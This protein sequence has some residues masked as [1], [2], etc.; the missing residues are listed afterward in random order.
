MNTPKK[1]QSITERMLERRRIQGVDGTVTVT[2]RLE[3]LVPADAQHH[4]G[5]ADRTVTRTQNTFDV[6]PQSIRM[7]RGNYRTV[8]TLEDDARLAESVK[9]HGVRSSVWVRQIEV[10]GKPVFELVAGWRRLRAAISVGLPQIPIVSY[11]VLTDAEADALQLLENEQR[12]QPHIL[13]T[14]FRF[15]DMHRRHNWTQDRVAH[16][17]G[18]SKGTV[19]ILMRA[20]ELL[21]TLPVQEQNAMRHQIV[22]FRML[23]NVVGE[24]GDDA[25]KIARLQVILAQARGE[26]GE[27]E[28][29]DDKVEGSLVQG[30]AAKPSTK[31]RQK[32]APATSYTAHVTKRG[33]SCR[34]ELRWT[35]TRVKVAPATALTDTV[36]DIRQLAA[37]LL[38]RF[39]SAGVRASLAGAEAAE[40][41]QRLETLRRISNS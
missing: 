34:Y 7:D 39:E 6:D 23:R 13:D 31:K 30:G 29:P 21:E 38:G 33:A 24:D 28:G 27:E 5:R 3:G 12:K 4:V 17:M 35:L 10:D 2:K 22:S 41:D 11:G 25:A 40:F 37:D 20:A 18:R 14:A 32:P 15:L 16:E 19:S 8:S 36:R 9:E 1:K 26:G